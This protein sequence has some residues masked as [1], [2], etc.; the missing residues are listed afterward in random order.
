MHSVPFKS[1]LNNLMFLVYEKIWK[2]LKNYDS[3]SYSILSYPHSTKHLYSLW[4]IVKFIE[5]LGIVTSFT[6]TINSSI[7]AD[8]MIFQLKNNRP[9]GP[10]AIFT[11]ILKMLLS[12]ALNVFICVLILF[13]FF[14]DEQLIIRREHLIGKNFDG[15]RVRYVTSP[16][17]PRKNNFF[18]IRQ[19]KTFKSQRLRMRGSLK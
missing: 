17:S 10:I 8:S 15:A 13:S 18:C 9:L 5:N 16:Q 1:F 4:L 12:I 6:S 2:S 7:Q 11:K 19:K 14:R 3:K